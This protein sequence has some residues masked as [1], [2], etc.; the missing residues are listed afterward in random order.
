M[1]KTGPYLGSEDVVI[2]GGKRGVRWGWAL[3]HPRLEVSGVFIKECG[4]PSPYSK[5]YLLWDRDVAV[6]FWTGLHLFPKFWRTQFWKTKSAAVRLGALAMKQEGGFF[7]DG[8]W[9]FGNPYAEAI[10]EE[11]NKGNGWKDYSGLQ[12]YSAARIL[13]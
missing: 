3:K 7:S 4:I 9:T 8:A 6:C 11:R 10:F 1:T 12:G 2:R 5:A 13:R